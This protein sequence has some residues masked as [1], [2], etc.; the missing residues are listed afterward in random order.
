M[1]DQASKAACNRGDILHHGSWANDIWQMTS[2][3]LGTELT[4]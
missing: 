4:E 2:D 1:N 3:V